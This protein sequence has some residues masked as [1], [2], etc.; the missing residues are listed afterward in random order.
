MSASHKVAMVTGAG[1]AP[2]GTPPMRRA[3]AWRF[4]VAA[5]VSGL[6]AA[7]IGGFL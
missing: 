5:P 1:E 6:V 4:W 3:A 7:W 2:R